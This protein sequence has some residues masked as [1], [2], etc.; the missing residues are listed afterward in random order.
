MSLATVFDAI[1]NTYLP[2]LWIVGIFGL[3]VLMGA[4]AGVLLWLYIEMKDRTPP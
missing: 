2:L 1:W 3:L 4:A